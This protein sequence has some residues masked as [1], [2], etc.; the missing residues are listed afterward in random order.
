MDGIKAGKLL[1]ITGIAVFV[2]LFVIPVLMNV[3]DLIS[4]DTTTAEIINAERHLSNVR[5]GS[6]QDRVYHVY[7]GRYTVNGTEY[8]HRVPA[9]EG[10]AVGESVEI[11]YKP[12]DPSVVMMNTHAVRDVN[13]LA[14]FFSLV[15][16]V[17]GLIKYLSENADP[18]GE[19]R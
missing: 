11:R 19:R 8:E 6:R 2:V 3:S 10:T 15:V 14:L 17:S 18:F 5:H 16:T 9:P 13:T 7:T 12:S 1:I 4:Y